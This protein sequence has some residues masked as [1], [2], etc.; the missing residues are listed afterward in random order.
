MSLSRAW[1]ALGICFMF[2]LTGRP[3]SAYVRIIFF[4]DYDNKN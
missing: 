1:T 2:G 4:C 3:Y